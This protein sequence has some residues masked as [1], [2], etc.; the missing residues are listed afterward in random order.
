MTEKIYLETYL[1]WKVSWVAL[2]STTHTRFSIFTACYYPRDAENK[3]IAESTTISSELSD[4][5]RAAAIT[6][7]L[8]VIDHL[9]EKHQHVLLKNNSLYGVTVVLHSSG[10]HSLLSHCQ[11]LIKIWTLNGVKMKDTTPKSL[12]AALEELASIVM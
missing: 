4:L 11:I 5:S 1:P 2:F 3:I 8:T 9:R 12:W 6:S 7:V 10:H